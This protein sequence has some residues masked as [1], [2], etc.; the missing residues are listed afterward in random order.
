MTQ[1]SGTWLVQHYPK[2]DV[3]TPR[4]GKREGKGSWQVK[5]AWSPGAW[6]E[7]VERIEEHQFKLG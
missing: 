2:S 1:L 5:K 6:T 7:S 3:S 4:V